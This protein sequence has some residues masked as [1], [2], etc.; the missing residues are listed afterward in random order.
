MDPMA[1]IKPGVL[2]HWFT[3]EERF[4]RLPGHDC[5]WHCEGVHVINSG[6]G[7]AGRNFEIGQHSEE[8]T[9]D[10]YPPDM[11]GEDDMHRVRSASMSS[12][13]SLPQEY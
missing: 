10:L 2:E 4:F 12:W 9:E 6:T 7:A 8:D 13:L 1:V 11:H 5:D 3:E